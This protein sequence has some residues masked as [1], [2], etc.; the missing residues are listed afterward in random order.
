MIKLRDYQQR[1]VNQIWDWF[2]ANKEGNP[3]AV[4]PTGAGKSIICAQL[5]MDAISFKCERKIR[6]LIITH[7][8]ELVEQNH[9]KFVTIAPHVDT[10]IYS[11]SL[12]R[13]D[14]DNQVIFASIQSAWSKDL[15]VF[16]LVICDECHRIPHEETGTYRTLFAKLTELNPTLRV[17]GLTA[18]P[19]RMRGGH[20]C[21]G[22]QRLFHSVA[23]EVSIV[24]LMDQGHLCR[25]SAWKSPITADL[26]SVKV[27]KGEFVMSEQSAIMINTG[28]TSDAVADVVKKAAAR[29]S[30][31]VFCA[32]IK[33]CKHTQI[34][35]LSHGWDA[36]VITGQTPKDEREFLIA[37][38]RAGRIRVL[39]N[40]AV[41]TTGFDAPIV[42]CVV[43]LRG[44][45]STSLYIQIAGRGMRPHPE[46]ANCLLLDYV[47]N[48]EEHG[49]LDDPDI[50]TLALNKRK[51]EAPTKYCPKCE[52]IIHLAAKSCPECGYVYPLKERDVQKLASEA[53]LMSA[54]R[55]KKI[56]LN[57]ISAVTAV[58]HEKNGRIS[59]LL[60][61]LGFDTN[62]PH[63]MHKIAPRQVCT[64]WLHPDHSVYKWESFRKWWVVNMPSHPV[65]PNSTDALE[66]L[67]NGLENQ[68]SFLLINYSEKYPVIEKKFYGHAE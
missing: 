9:E 19:F 41:L 25:V 62:K 67:K 30:I 32:D 57:T 43:M 26:S 10:G 53:I 33:H 55:G 36:E 65:P 17:I 2:R 51:G 13:K 28:V 11:A 27:S 16:D 34:E 15:G 56:R 6:V 68:P 66:V 49:C 47:G 5:A 35:F 42:D 20:L 61:Y 1:S 24:E 63:P 23:A 38:F 46:K 60:K 31:L 8:K 52:A 29:Q 54:E 12:K 22:K 59:V 58:R 4:L 37:E 48:I 64:E 39:I 40:C 3:L 50:Y 44:T 18:T 21:K 7:S 14:T 45:K